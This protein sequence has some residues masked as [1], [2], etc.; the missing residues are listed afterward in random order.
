[1]EISKE[2]GGVKKS[3][4]AIPLAFELG[5]TIAIPLVLFALIGRFADKS[6]A[7]SPWLLLLG[8]LL[9]I[10]IST[11]LVYKKVKAIM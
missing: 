3:F 7:T 6:L 5:F 11:V 9:A 10:A 1:M 4:K 2:N 8:I